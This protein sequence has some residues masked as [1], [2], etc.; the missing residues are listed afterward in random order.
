[1]SEQKRYH[2]LPKDRGISAYYVK[3]G[4]MFWFGGYRSWCWFVISQAF[5]FI[6]DLL[7]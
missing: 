1:M 2:P 5:S 7:R 4:I 3:V 6:G